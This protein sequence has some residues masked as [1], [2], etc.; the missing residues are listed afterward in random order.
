MKLSIPRLTLG[1]TRNHLRLLPEDHQ[2]VVEHGHVVRRDGVEFIILSD[3]DIPKDD[4]RKE[5]S[6]RLVG[7]EAQICPTSGCLISI[8][9]HANARRRPP[10]R[11]QH[12][13]AQAYR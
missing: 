4:R 1:S 3:Y 2:Y 9:R 5:S 6:R 10:Y 8:H 12:R 7:I 13:R 11:R